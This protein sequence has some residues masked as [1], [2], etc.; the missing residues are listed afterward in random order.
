M[1]LS[2]YDEHTA[3]LAVKVILP[4]DGTNVVTLVPNATLERRIDSIVVGSICAAARDVYVRL[5]DGTTYTN[6]GAK[7]VPAGAGGPTVPTVEILSAI[8]PATVTG[9]VLP[10][11]ASIQIALGTAAGAGEEV[12][13]IA[14]GGY[15]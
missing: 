7:T 3:Y 12:R 15:V 9:L 14:I 2:I 6:L 13:F 11:G 10:V 4:A 1:G 5:N 8:L